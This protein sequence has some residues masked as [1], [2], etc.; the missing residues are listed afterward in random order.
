[1]QNLKYGRSM[2]CGPENILHVESGPETF[3][4]SPLLIVCNTFSHHI[5][6]FVED[7][8]IDGL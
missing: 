7:L 2:D 3:R 4:T 1:M 8:F 6:F 5:T